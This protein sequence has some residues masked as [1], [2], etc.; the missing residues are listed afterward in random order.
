MHHQSVMT[1]VG[2]MGYQPFLRNRD[3]GLPYFLGRLYLNDLD[4]C[5]LLLAFASWLLYIPFCLIELIISPQL[6]R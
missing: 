3:L 5:V 4:G 1:W 6:H 2:T